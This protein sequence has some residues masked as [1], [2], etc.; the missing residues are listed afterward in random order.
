MSIRPYGF[1][2]TVVTLLRSLPV[3]VVWPPKR[4]TLV[5]CG[6]SWPTELMNKIQ[7]MASPVLFLFVILAA[8][9]TLT[10]PSR[11]KPGAALS[12]QLGFGGLYTWH[13][14]A[15]WQMISVG[16]D[17]GSGS[18]ACQSYMYFE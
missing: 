5:S 17:C 9:V 10:V 18:R 7:R 6:G 12:Q 2:T 3:H 14:Q 11:K 16:T 4:Q 15:A 1:L 13:G 8:V